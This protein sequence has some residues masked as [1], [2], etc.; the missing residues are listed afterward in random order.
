MSR[1]KQPV[2]YYVIVS[3]FSIIATIAIL[4]V[5]KETMSYR[6]SQEKYE[7]IKETVFVRENDEIKLDTSGLNES[8]SN[9]LTAWIKIENTAIDYPLV[10]GM[11]NSYYLDHD[12]YGNPDDAGAIFIDARNTKNFA[13]KKTIIYGHNRKD[14]SM[15]ASLHSYADKSFAVEHSILTITTVGGSE[16]N[17]DLLCAGI[18]QDQIE[19]V[20]GLSINENITESLN[21][22]ANLTF[23]N[24]YNGNPIII[25]STCLEGEDRRI[26]IFQLQKE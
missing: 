24:E 15:F 19:A 26:V 16:L 1:R 3:V 25:L 12:A 9:A 11:N 20:Y 14:G 13:D 5:I 6:N 8:V 17:Y 22:I 18:V 23:Y 21:N 10:Q 4:M 2:L 7:E